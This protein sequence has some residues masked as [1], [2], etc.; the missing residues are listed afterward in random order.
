M[1]LGKQIFVAMLLMIAGCAQ[2]QA[3]EPTDP[4]LGPGKVATVD[5]AAIP[6]SVFRLYTIGTLRKNAD[7]LTPEE[8]KKVVD[9]LVGIEVLVG[10]AAKRGI[11]K[12]RTVAAELELQRLQILARAM[13][14]RYIEEN[15]PTEEE[16]K[17]VYEENLPRLSAQQYKAHH[18]LVETK[19][20]A[21]SVISQ[22]NKGKDF[23]ALAKERAAG[24]TGPNGGDLGW[25]TAD[26]MVPEVVAAVKQLKVGS[27]T[28]E[29]V[30]SQYGYH[31][32][33][34][35]DTR[36][37][38]PPTLD[39]VRKDLAN[40]VDRNKLESYVKSLKKSAKVAVE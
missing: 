33:L 8:R 4:S 26:S 14:S 25:F 3:A 22:L 27:Y 29:P 18:I 35:D 11:P 21:E 19:D 7:D 34:L 32:I 24:P 38:T 10:E 1:K 31:V 9:D 12:E 15:P 13:A 40:V 30:K 36:T 16:L 39:S 28:K 6:E 2:D 20:E 17:A 23:A 5:G 37:G